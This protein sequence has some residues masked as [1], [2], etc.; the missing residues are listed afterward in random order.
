MKIKSQKDFWSGLRFVLVGVAFAWGATAYRFGPPCPAD[1]PCA[2]SLWLRFTQLSANPGPGFFPFGLGLLL[3]LL[4]GIILFKSLTLESPDGDAIGRVAWR[5]LGVLIGSVVI[6]GVLLPR[7]GL[8]VALPVLVIV[9]SLASTEFRW[10]GT[11][12]N[13]VVLTVLS[14]AM[15]VWGL[16][17]GIP[18]WP[19]VF[20]LSN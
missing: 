8:V 12:I 2:G 1:A 10:R 15:F 17:L 11:L 20:G 9:S 6:F 5:P 18:V 19:T 13:A 7:F 3:A 4:G 14:W 16:K